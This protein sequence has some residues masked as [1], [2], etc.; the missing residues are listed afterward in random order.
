MKKKTIN[1]PAPKKYK[2]L[3]K[4]EQKEHRAKMAGKKIEIAPTGKTDDLNEEVLVDFFTKVLKMDL[5]S[6]LIT[7]MSSL[8]DFPENS[9]IYV[10]RIK[11]VYG[12]DFS[13]NKNLL[14]H[15]IVRKI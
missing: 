11:N 1:F 4:Q 12:K 6:C 3:S 13:K 5:Y 2:T 9:E 8:H 10:A 14:I 15:D 7:D